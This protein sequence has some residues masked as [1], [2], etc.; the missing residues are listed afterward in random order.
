MLSDI[1]ETNNIN[2]LGGIKM[3]I[4]KKRIERWT[5]GK[6]SIGKIC[7]D[8]LAVPN[9]VTVTLD[10]EKIIPYKFNS[11]GEPY[12]THEQERLYS[13]KEEELNRNSEDFIPLY[14][15]VQYEEKVFDVPRS[16]FD[17]IE[18]I[19][20]SLRCLSDLREMLTNRHIYAKLHGY[21]ELN[22]F[23]L[24][25]CYCLERNGGMM[26]IDEKLIDSIIYHDDVEPYEVFRKNNKE[27][28]LSSPGF[29]IPSP[30][31][32]C[33]CCGKMLTIDDLKNNRCVFEDG[34][35]FHYSCYRNYR[36]LLEVDR[37][38]RMLMDIIYK[39]TDYTFELLPNGYCKEKCC[40]HI[41]WILFHTI[42]GD[43][44][45]GWRKR[46]ISIEWQENY[47]S[48]NLE[49]LFKNEN[50]TKWTGAD[51][52]R[53]IHAWGREKAYEYLTK[54]L[55]DVNPTYSRY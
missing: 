26:A 52:K 29:V 42:D 30:N 6:N 45:V 3:I 35:D 4:E 51:G 34:K 23:M 21:G 18:G 49:E 27:I 33:P 5:D 12:F 13:F 32:T 17:S 28:T 25:G 54:V 22:E 16:S 43:I 19:K 48:F 44:I 47:K 15:T 55:K 36:R 41:P 38:T 46:V 37:F 10:G 40:S 7:L 31:S 20:K 8:K 39:K 11:F 9:T 53:G 14:V 50:V 2:N 24:F 1:S